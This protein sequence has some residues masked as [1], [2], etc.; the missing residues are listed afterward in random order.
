MTAFPYPVP[1]SVLASLERSERVL[2]GT[3]EN[4]DAD[5]LGSLVATGLALLE[6]GRGVAMVAIDE[7]PGTLGE[8]TGLDR[9][10]RLEGD[11]SRYDLALIFDCHRRERLGPGHDR[12]EQADRVVAIDHH[13]LDPRGSDCDEV[14]LVDD[15]PATAM[16]VLSLLRELHDMPLGADKASCLYAGLLTDTGG[17]RHANT[18]RDALLAAADLVDQG[19]DA[20]AIADTML[21]RRRPEALHLLGEVLL[22]TGYHLDGRVAAAVVDHDLLDRTR[23]ASD[24]TEGLVS[25]LT[26]IEGVAVAVMLK[27]VAADSWRVSLRSGAEV[28]VDRIARDFGGGGHHRAAAFSVDGVSRET[29]EAELL[30]RIATEIPGGPE[31][32]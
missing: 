20:A 29:L 23:A 25:Y 22:A 13:P 14:W 21:Y 1:E 26:S 7:V 16:M 18:T 11:P 24:E 19:A 31:R 9:I 28:R 2:L 3:H 27:Q 4:P 15:A 6:R 10:P 30:D 17:F 8:L 12:L 32:P 5:G